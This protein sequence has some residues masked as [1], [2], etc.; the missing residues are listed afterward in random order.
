MEELHVKYYFIKITLVSK[1]LKYNLSSLKIKTLQK[2]E[3]FLPKC[4]DS[5]RS[6]KILAHLTLYKKIK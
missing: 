3:D 1:D 6:D 2:A 4:T 5:H